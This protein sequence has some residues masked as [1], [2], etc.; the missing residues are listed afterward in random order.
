MRDGLFIV[1]EGV[2]GAG[3]TTQSER[4]AERLRRAG[5]PTHLTREPSDGPVGAM[6]RQI[7]TGRLALPAAPG[8]RD[9]WA[10]MAL[11]FAADRLDHLEASIE[12]SLAGGVTV[13]CDRYDH[14]SVAYQASTGGGLDPAT[15]AWIRGLNRHVRRPDLTL[16][17]DVTPEEAARRRSARGGAEELF[18]RAELQRALADAYREIDRHFPE[19]RLVHVDADRGVDEVAA[20]ILREVERLGDRS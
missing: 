3:T 19:D 5:T 18:D 17:L 6:I 2:D 11:L 1:L 7:L 9:A 20:S 8:A 16:V 14:S 12:P 13:V 10:T 4:L 15:V